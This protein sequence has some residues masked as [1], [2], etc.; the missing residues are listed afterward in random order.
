MQVWMFFGMYF[1]LFIS[2]FNFFNKGFVLL[3][4]SGMIQF[5]F[6][7]YFKF[8]IRKYIKYKFK[9]GNVLVL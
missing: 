3:C 7:F 2:V 6:D 5:E 1:L 4:V 8:K 9:Q